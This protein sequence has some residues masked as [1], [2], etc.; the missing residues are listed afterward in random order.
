MVKDGRGWHGDTPGH[1]EASLKAGAKSAMNRP[2][3][4]EKELK[5]GT[6]V[7]FNKDSDRVQRILPFHTGYE[8]KVGEVVG[9][10]HKGDYIVDFGAH[11][12]IS[13]SR[14]QVVLE[15]KDIIIVSPPKRGYK[16][17]DAPTMEK[18]EKFTKKLHG[19]G[20]DYDWHIDETKSAI[21]AT[22]AYHTIDESGLYD[23]I[24]DFTI[25]FPK[26]EPMDNFKLTFGS[27]SQHQAK[28][29]MLRDYLED[30]IGSVLD[31]LG[32]G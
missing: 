30:T 23:P 32:Y 17:A 28:K 31:E 14:Y 21:K 18:V 9:R 25:T 2:M 22:N 15:P 11:P 8:D 27:G 1:R 7:K 16:H 12:T 13:G 19:S 10:F 29:Y 26:N 24:V 5:V 6:K 20:I 3:R 4:K